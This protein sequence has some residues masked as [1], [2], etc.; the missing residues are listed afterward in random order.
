MKKLTIKQAKD[1][2]LKYEKLIDLL[3]KEAEAKQLEEQIKLL[4]EEC[5]LDAFMSTKELNEEIRIG[6]VRLKSFIRTN[7]DSSKFRTDNPKMYEDYKTRADY[8]IN[9]KMV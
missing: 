3:L 5:G 4:R 2:G 1:N 8:I 9:R 7:F 6:K